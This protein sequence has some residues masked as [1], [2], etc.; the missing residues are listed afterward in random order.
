MTINSPSLSK[1][2]EISAQTGKERAVLS[3]G[4]INNLG[5][6]ADEFE[7]ILDSKNGF[8]AFENALQFFHS[9]SNE[10]Y[11]DINTWN[12]K[13]LWIN[14]YSKISEKYAFFAQDT[15]GIQFIVFENKFYK[16]DPETENIEFI[17][18]SFEDWAKIILDDYNYMTGH[19]IAHEWQLVNGV[20]KE[21]S[22]LLPIIPFTC[23]GQFDI[24]NL[25]ESE[26]VKGM[27][28]RAI[29]SN[30]IKEL[31]DGTAIEFTFAS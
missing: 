16:F 28:L 8:I 11:I 31:A 7:K 5:S 10:Q 13:S 25:F 6:L 30:Q 24:K 29:F 1:L 26:M 9:G 20:I 15:F 17:A 27:Q 12:E 3:E 2:L 19:S 22:R 4:I 18:N 14:E 23:D 21:N